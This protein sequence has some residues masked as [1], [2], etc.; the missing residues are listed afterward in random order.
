MVDKMDCDQIRELLDGYALG[1]ADIADSKAIEEHVAD[2]IR[3]WDEL[4]SSQAT[5]ALLA[6]AVPIEDAPSRLEERILA[7]ARRQSKRGDRP[8]FWQRLRIGTWPATAGAF[9][10]VSVAALVLSGLLH[11]QVQDLKDQNSD[12]KSQMQ[13]ATARFENSSAQT[14]SQLADQTVMF[15]VLSDDAHKDV[16]VTAASSNGGEA[17]YTWSPSK[18]LGFV[19][20]DGLPSLAAGK[21]YQ[22]WFVAGATMYALKPFLSTDGKCE[23]TM[24]LSFLDERPDG[25]GITV[26]DTPGGSTRPST[27]WVMYGSFAGN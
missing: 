5:A 26:E 24:D 21:V 2:C 12:L 19:L 23:V 13:T 15:S 25:I 11:F 6:L 16:E 27:P 9:G 20:C 18:A 3:C 22:L 7:Q 1:A 17:Y 14:S 4:S 10:V 8:P